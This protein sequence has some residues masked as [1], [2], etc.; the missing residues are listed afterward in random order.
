[1]EIEEEIYNK[2]RDTPFKTET[3]QNIP[4]DADKDKAS[5]NLA[6]YNQ[7]LENIKKSL[8]EKNPKKFLIK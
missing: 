2:Y 7:F 4:Q 6:K 5:R 3:H 1:M 8:R